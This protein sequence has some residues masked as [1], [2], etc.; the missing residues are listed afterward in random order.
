MPLDKAQ[1]NRSIRK[2]RSFLKKPRRRP[3]PRRIHDFRTHT[4]RLEVMLEAF[5]MNSRRNERRT[6]QTLPSLRK[7]AGKIRDMDV[8]ME[9]ASSVRVDGE[10][11]CS[12]QLLEYLGA[13]RYAQAKA[14]RALVEKHGPILRK[15]LKRTG[16][17]LES[18]LLQS[19]QSPKHHRPSAP[20]TAMA[21]ALELSSTLHT[22][23][24]L[25]RRN[26]HSYRLKVKELRNVLEMSDDAKRQPFVDKLTEVK[27]AIGEWH[28]WEELVSIATKVLS[29]DKSC[30][31]LR[32]LKNISRVK[33]ENARSLTYGMRQ[34]Y[35]DS[36]EPE[37]SK[38]K[39]RRKVKLTR[40]VLVATSAIAD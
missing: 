31:L 16:A 39:H 21:T 24:R 18:L 20:V 3:S 4:R 37:D 14:M 1:P 11:D 25:D 36:N 22:P 33:F 28:D 29:H 40:P 12:L 23:A 10:E 5:A 27:D 9:R 6:L 38:N 15:R 8:L 13:K 30:K 7:R 34:V 17:R 2:L 35:L 32:E 19:D 26:L